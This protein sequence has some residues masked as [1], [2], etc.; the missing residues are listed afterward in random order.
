MLV[1][2]AKGT[3]SSFVVRVPGL[4]AAA[5]FTVILTAPAPAADPAP[6]DWA[7]HHDHQLV[8]Q[9]VQQWAADYPNLVTVESIGESVQGRQLWLLT[10][11]NRQ[12]G[13][14]SEK[15]ALW[16]DGNSDGGQ[17]LSKEVALYFIHFLLTNY[18]TD[19][20]VRDALDTRTLYIEPNANPDSGEQIIQAPEMGKIMGVFRDGTLYPWDKDGDGLAAEDPPED[21][22][23]DGLVVSMRVQDPEG[24]W[25]VAE[26]YPLMVERQPGDGPDDGPFYR[27][28]PTEGID[29]D[30]DGRINEDWLSA[31]DSNRVFPGNWQ[32]AFRQFGAQPYPLYTPEPK[33][34][35]DA[36]LARPN[37]AAL[38]SLHTAGQFPGGTLW[39]PPASV[40]PSDFSPFDMEYLYRVTGAEYERLMRDQEKNPYSCATAANV[41]ESLLDP[42]IYGT[43][44]DWAYI[45]RGII[46]WTPEIWSRGVFDYNGDCT[47]SMDEEWRW[48]QEEWGGKPFLPWTRAEHPE[49]GVVEVGGWRNDFDGSGSL[50]LEGWLHQAQLN[51]P[52][53]LYVFESLPRIALANVRSERVEDG[54]Y[55]VS[56]TVRNLGFLPTSSTDYGAGL[57]VKRG[58]QTGVPSYVPIAKP[59]TALL[60]SA[61]GEILTDAVVDVGHLRGS[62]GPTP[63]SDTEGQTSS[64]DVSWEVRAPEGTSVTVHAGTPRAGFATASLRLQE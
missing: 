31:F 38:V 59:V 49:L 20:R 34:I 5:L 52:W 35:V 8:T 48:S 47:I 9:M 44:I 57:I 33:A 62:T 39:Q 26:G 25:K 17:V 36:V 56:A 45:N 61:A 4:L 30:N 63:D 23:D 40:P 24:D 3:G 54:V 42:P 16:I 15:P 2:I 6:I 19:E 18:D 64:A 28:Y 14:A 1:E 51:V 37:I 27:L 29:N 41:Y 13:K 55:R 7:E 60:Q 32:P 53:L 43:L 12:T 50:P 10:L 21:I 46:A 58:V 11:T 22:N